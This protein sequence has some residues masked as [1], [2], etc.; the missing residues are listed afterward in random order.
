MLPYPEVRCHGLSLHVGCLFW[1][2]DHLQGVHL[3]EGSDLRK[4]IYYL[5]LANMEDICYSNI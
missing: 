5:A 4:R 2:P 1:V 3:A